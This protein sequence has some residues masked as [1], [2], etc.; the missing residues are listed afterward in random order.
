MKKLLPVIA[1]LAFIVVTESPAQTAPRTEYTIQVSEP[2]LA[3]KAGETSSL[4]INLAKSKSFSRYKAELRL[5][6][7]LPEGISA[8]FE[9]ATGL[10]DVSTLYITASNEVKPGHYPLVVRCEMGRK[11]KAIQVTLQ[12]EDRGTTIVT[13]N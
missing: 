4:T 3:V 8:R 11:L 1:L 13:H 7:S 6:S 10:F 12:I 5:T 2:V 9:P